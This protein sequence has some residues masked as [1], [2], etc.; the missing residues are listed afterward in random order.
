MNVKGQHFYTAFPMGSMVQDR[1]TGFKGMVTGF[2]CFITGCNQH[3]VTPKVD[4]KGAKVD[5]AW[6]D[7]GRLERTSEE[8]FRLPEDAQEAPEQERRAARG[9]DT[10]PAIR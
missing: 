4:E 8:L 10:P 6:I 2:T 9:G 7:E 5:A 1:I 3:L